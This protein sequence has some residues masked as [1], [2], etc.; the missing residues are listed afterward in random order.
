MSG[1]LFVSFVA[2]KSGTWRI[3]KINE[4]IGESLPLAERLEVY[5]ACNLQAIKPLIGCFEASQ[6]MFPTA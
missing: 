2:G 5:E 6:V 3:D 1:P 4:V